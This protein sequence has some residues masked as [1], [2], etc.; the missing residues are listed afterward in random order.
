MTG[1]LVAA[2]ASIVTGV[3]LVCSTVSVVE[4]EDTA[5]V[6]VATASTV[7]SGDVA[8]TVVE[9]SVVIRVV[10][11]W[12]VVEVGWRVVEVGWRVVEVGWPVVEVGWRVV[13]V[14]WRVVEIGWRVVE[15]AEGLS[16]KS[17]S[18]TMPV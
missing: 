12:R 3:V 5:W 10:V 14:S 15:D 16:T 18:Q 17:V 4:G 2:T 1:R 6:T 8:W 7:T 11:G 9:E 13:E